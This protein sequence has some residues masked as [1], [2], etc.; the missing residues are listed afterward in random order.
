[1]QKITLNVDRIVVLQRK[2]G[3]D[4]IRIYTD[5]PKPMPVFTDPAIFNL[6][7]TQDTGVQYVKDNFGID[8]EVIQ[9]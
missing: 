4:I 3:M 5:L 2:H 1:M 8:A 9:V 7:V 6:D